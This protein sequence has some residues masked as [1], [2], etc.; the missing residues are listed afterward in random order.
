MNKEKI[1]EAI[2]TLQ[3]LLNNFVDLN[4]GVCKELFKVEQMRILQDLQTTIEV[5]KAMMNAKYPEEIEARKMTEFDWVN[6]YYIVGNKYIPYSFG[7]PEARAYI[8]GYNDAIKD[9]RL[10]LAKCLG[11]M[12]EVIVKTI[13]DK[14]YFV[15]DGEVG[16][17]K[18]VSWQGGAEYLAKAITQTINGLFV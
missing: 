16:A 17:P 6:Y 1:K 14:Q 13:L 15:R 10:W 12:E 8:L 4:Y 18:W 5:L 9:F 3:N 2:S 11:E 7:S